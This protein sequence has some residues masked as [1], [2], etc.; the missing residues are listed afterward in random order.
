[1][2]RRQEADLLP[3]DTEIERTLQIL[4]RTT[5]AEYKNMAN[6]RDRLQAIPKEEKEV[7]RI[8]G[9]ILWRTFG[10][11]LSKRSTR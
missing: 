5:S 3:Q 9:L 1:M 2:H 6:Q 10:G 11:L 8:K 7:E 4:R